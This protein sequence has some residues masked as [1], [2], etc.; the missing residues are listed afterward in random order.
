[1]NF[2]LVKNPFCLIGKG[3]TSGRRKIIETFL[4]INII[5]KIIETFLLINVIIKS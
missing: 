4:L 2:K 5:V 3:S 1:M